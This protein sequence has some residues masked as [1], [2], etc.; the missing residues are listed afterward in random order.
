MG[1][2]RD[3]SQFPDVRRDRLN[4]NVARRTALTSGY[5]WDE[6]L[7][8]FALRHTATGRKSWIVQ[9][10]H[11]QD[12][13]RITLGTFPMMKAHDA[14]AEARRILASA[15][16]DGLPTRRAQEPADAALRFADYVP[17]FWAHYTHHWKPST[18]RANRHYIQNHFIPA[19]GERAIAS[20]TRPDIV[21]WRDGMARREGAF[22]R[23]IPVLSVMLGYAETLGY[24]PH[25]SNP[26]KGIARYKR[27]LKERYLS[28]REYQRLGAV[29]L[30]WAAT[31]PIAIAAIWL[32]IYLG[33]RKGEILALRWEWIGET[34]I[35][36]PDSKTGPKRLYLN[37][38]SASVLAGLGRQSGGRVL[39]ATFGPRQLDNAWVEIRSAAGIPDVRLHDLR[40]SFASVAIG[41]GISLSK[42]GGLLGHAL[43]ETTVRYAHLADDMIGEAASRV[44]GSMARALGLVP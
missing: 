27:L 12:V 34:Y 15:A 18:Q 33:A 17:I 4:G 41:H 7:K 28:A 9:Y 36:L 10:R 39:G 3:S 16:L 37:R 14:R 8:G 1:P 2:N 32:L 26:C 22:N 38:Q 40:H 29:L 23:A 42:V 20:L 30:E 31:R 13:R 44:S 35:D 19:F 6:E 5:I 24:R 21:A 11:R 25:G 43:P